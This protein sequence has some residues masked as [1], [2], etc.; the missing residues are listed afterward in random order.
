M[1]VHYSPRSGLTA[2][3][4][5]GDAIRS[6]LFHEDKLAQQ[7]FTKP[8]V[9]LRRFFHTDTPSSQQSIQNFASKGAAAP[10]PSRMFRRACAVE[11]QKAL[12]SSNPE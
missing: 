11:V 5:D 10:V 9:C 7:C 12:M 8:A 1:K 3:P 6:S 2:Q 4:R